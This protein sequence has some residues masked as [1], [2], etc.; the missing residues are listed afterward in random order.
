MDPNVKIYVGNAT[1]TKRFMGMVTNFVI[2][3]ISID[4]SKQVTTAHFVYLANNTLY[5]EDVTLSVAAIS[6]YD[7]SGTPVYYYELT[8]KSYDT[9][10]FYLAVL[11]NGTLML[12]DKDDVALSDGLF[13]LKA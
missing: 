8:I 5:E 3:S 2:T 4:T 11:N 9:Q 1:Y 7:G 6:N 12:C 10:T 13:T